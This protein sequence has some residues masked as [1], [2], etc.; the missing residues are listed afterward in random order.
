MNHWAW[1]FDPKTGGAIVTP[2]GVCGF[3]PLA[4]AQVLDDR[5]QLCQ[6]ESDQDA[7]LSKYEAIC[8]QPEPEVKP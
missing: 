2:S 7:I 6:S 4:D 5:L 3:L 1:E 8:T